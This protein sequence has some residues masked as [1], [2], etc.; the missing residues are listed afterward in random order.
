VWTW[1]LGPYLTALARVRGAAGVLAG[2]RLVE[3]LAPRLGEAGVG[4]LAEIFDAEPPHQARGAFAQAW[5]V[6]EVLRA[7]REDLGLFKR[8]AS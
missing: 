5:S 3:A 8:E 1:L 6:A 4:T 7:A 2:R